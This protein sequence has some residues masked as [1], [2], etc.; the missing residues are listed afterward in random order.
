MILSFCIDKIFCSMS[1]SRLARF[2]KGQER[3]FSTVKWQKTFF[4]LFSSPFAYLSI[5]SQIKRARLAILFFFF[6]WVL[7][8]IP[9]DMCKLKK[10]STNEIYPRP[11]KKGIKEIIYEHSVFFIH[12]FTCAYIVSVISSH[13]TPLRPH[14]FP[15]TPPCFQAETVLPLSLILLKR[16]HKHNQKDKAFFS[17]S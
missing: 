10:H 16:R 3:Y 17:L 12:L 13:S 4:F 9:M 11:W 8:I 14:P 2:F 15:P 6:F 5:M 1:H 7:G